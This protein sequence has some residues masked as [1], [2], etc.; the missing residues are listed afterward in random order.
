LTRSRNPHG[1]SALEIVAR[2]R[3]V[4]EGSGPFQDYF[5]SLGGHP[6]GVV[7]CAHGPMFPWTAAL[8]AMVFDAHNRE[9]PPHCRDAGGPFAY[10]PGDPYTLSLMS[11]DYAELHPVRAQMSMLGLETLIDVG[12]IS[13]FLVV[14]HGPRCLDITHRLGQGLPLDEAEEEKILQARVLPA[15]C[16]LIADKASMVHQCARVTG[17]HL[18]LSPDGAHWEADPFD[19]ERGQR[20]EAVA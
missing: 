19:W 12:G 15:V 16:Q 5:E 1:L 6:V 7:A 8:T 18:I 14:T 10:Y 20:I 2:A 11:E 4:L 13:E 9:W 17:V 3:E